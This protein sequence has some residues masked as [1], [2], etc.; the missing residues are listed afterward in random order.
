MPEDRG[1]AVPPA[2]AGD[3]QRFLWETL[4][5]L[6]PAPAEIVRRRRSIGRPGGD[7]APERPTQAPGRTMDFLVFPHERNPVLLVPRR[8]RSAAAA[9]LRAY[10]A[11][12]SA[13]DRLRFG[14]AAL[15]A[16]TG[17]AELLPDRIRIT[18]PPGMLT[19]ST[20][21]T[22]IVAYLRAV[23]GPD[24]LVALHVGGPRA[25]RKPVLQAI[26]PGGEVIAFVKV[27]V[28]PLTEDLVR[29]EAAALDL[30][31]GLRLSHLRPP[32]LIHHGRWRG[33]EVLVQEAFPAGRPAQG[34]TGLTAAMT[35][36]AGVRGVER[37]TLAHSP[38]WLG[39]RS[40]LAELPRRDV[41]GPLLAVLES[42]APQA[43]AISLEFGSWHGDWTPWNMTMSLGRARVWDWERFEAGVPVGY[44]A[45]H[46]RLQGDIVRGGADPAAAAHT[47]LSGAAQTLAPFGVEPETAGLVAAL[48][49][50]EIAA[51]YVRDGQA[52]AGAKLGRID[53]WLLPALAHHIQRPDGDTPR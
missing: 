51:R 35:E 47:T 11:S 44:D 33:H 2:G 53:A 5:G 3:R 15:A 25:N 4:T 49:L 9:A 40:R 1:R 12:A 6:W 10:K 8:P 41:A 24:T 19:P 22:D 32:R 7:T 42:L 45:L 48:Y 13:A 16:A 18:Q 27:S 29:A 52:E 37:P 36:L 43:G 21:S 50:T 14:A 17:L 46:Y 20:D 30:L 31:G 23:L 34:L 28:S 38:Y 39:L 26:T